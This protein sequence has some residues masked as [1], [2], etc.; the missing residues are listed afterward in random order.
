MTH[1]N[2]KLYIYIYIYIHTKTMLY[3]YIYNYTLEISLITSDRRKWS[4]FFG[5]AEFTCPVI[6]ELGNV[7]LKA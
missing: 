3:K 2:K 6:S 5:G 1:V 4:I 7:D